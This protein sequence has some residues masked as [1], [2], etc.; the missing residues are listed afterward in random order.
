MF[1]VGIGRKTERRMNGECGEWLEADSIGRN[2][3]S[4]F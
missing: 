3:I 4:R 2:K 1:C